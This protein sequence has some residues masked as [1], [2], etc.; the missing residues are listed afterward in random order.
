MSVDVLAAIMTNPANALDCTT[1]PGVPDRDC[2]SGFLLADRAVGMALDGTAPSVAPTISP[3]APDGANGW[4]RAPV[5]VAWSVADAESSVT[6]SSG[7]APTAAGD[8]VALTLTCTA[9]SAGG[10]TTGTVTLRRDST[11]PTRPEIT[12]IAARRYTTATVPRAGRVA[13]HATDLTSGVDSCRVTGYGAGTGRH[14]LTAVATDDAGLTATTTLAYTVVRPAAISRLKLARGLTL[15]RLRSRGA[16]LSVRASSARTRLVVQLLA[17]V[18][19]RRIALGRITKRVPRGTSGIRVQITPAARRRLASTS[20]VTVEVT[21][22]GSAHG[23]KRTT[24]H[25]RR[26]SGHR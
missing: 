11:P 13:C 1:T 3:P 24:L 26:A 22:T 9:T 2:G 18:G 7:C 16:A 15:K 4:Y 25:A 23:S 19:S 17:Q 21:V 6:L 10:T 14:R 8:V 12:G 5:T 20:K